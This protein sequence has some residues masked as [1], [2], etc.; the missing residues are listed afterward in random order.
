MKQISKYVGGE[1]LH[2]TIPRGLEPKEFKKF[3]E[4]EIV[5]LKN[6]VYEKYIGKKYNEVL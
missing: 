6:E 4:K 5:L 3:I 1:R 2:F